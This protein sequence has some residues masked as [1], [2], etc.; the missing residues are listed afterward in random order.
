M[1]S[2]VPGVRALFQP[3]CPSLL[4]LA[5]NRL[6]TN[7]DS[8]SAGAGTAQGPPEDDEV[9]LLL[10]MSSCADLAEERIEVYG[11]VAVLEDIVCP[12]NRVR[13][14]IHI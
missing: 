6:A 2:G 9:V 1:L 13:N 12:E 10:A 4:V 3:D 5:F 8:H 7:D 11:I 14:T